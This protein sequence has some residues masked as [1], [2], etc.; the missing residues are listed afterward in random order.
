MKTTGIHRKKWILI[1]SLAVIVSCLLSIMVDR[2]SERESA[3]TT[4]SPKQLNLIVQP[5]PEAALE[6]QDWMLNFQNK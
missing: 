1:F 2:A 6:V 4:I 3:A 5:E